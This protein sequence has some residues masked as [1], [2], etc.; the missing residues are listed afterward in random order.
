MSNLVVLASAI[1][2]TS[3]SGVNVPSM[4]IVN[5]VAPAHVVAVNN[6]FDASRVGDSTV[7][8]AVDVLN[9]ARKA[10]KVNER[11]NRYKPGIQDRV[12]E[13]AKTKSDRVLIMGGKEAFPM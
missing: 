2:L 3:A 12:V 9:E 1:I 4:G 13:K 10:I 7:Q 5:T 11:R 6:T 8:T